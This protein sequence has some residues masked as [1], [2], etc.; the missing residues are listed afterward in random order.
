M[1]PKGAAGGLFVLALVAAFLAGCSPAG[2]RTAH[3][4]SASG[5]TA[6]AGLGDG[7]CAASLKIYN[8]SLRPLPRGTAMT[9]TAE[10]AIRATKATNPRL[11]SGA[12]FS[13]YAATFSAPIHLPDPTTALGSGPFA[14]RA[15][16]VV[17]VGNLNF[18]L[19]G[20]AERSPSAP[21]TNL[22][23][24]HHMLDVVDDATGLEP[25]SLDCA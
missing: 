17:E 16:W 24:L 1:Y 23:V 3:L 13:A 19:P 9:R 20:G 15:V 7:V 22:V 8:I 18:P 11:P 21:T 2:G 25:L 6:T 5:V 4:R 10:Q 12:T 14:N